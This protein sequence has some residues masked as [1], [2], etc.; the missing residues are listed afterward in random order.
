[1]TGC[2]DGDK[3]KVHYTG[4]LENGEVFDSSRTGDKPLEFVVGS[5]QVIPGFDSGVKGLA[6]NETKTITIPPEQA[7]GVKQEQLIFDVERSQ[8]PEG[9]EPQVGQ[10]LAISGQDGRQAP[11]WIT[12][13]NDSKVTLDGNHPLAGKTLIFE[14]ELIEINASN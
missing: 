13:V 14:I 6:A 5:G 11:V 9:L 10:Q 3:V 7:Y 4:K 8:L 2:K 12:A 1:M